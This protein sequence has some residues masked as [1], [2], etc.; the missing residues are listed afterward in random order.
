MFPKQLLMGQSTWLLLKKEK[1]LWAHPWFN[2]M[3][4]TLCPQNLLKN[5][6]QRFFF[7]YLPLP[8]INFFEKNMSDA[9][10]HLEPWNIHVLG[11]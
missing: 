10:A 3:N 9:Q 1:K 7:H 5:H 11:V 2:N 4:H 6:H 8:W